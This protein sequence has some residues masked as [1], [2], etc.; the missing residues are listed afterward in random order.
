[1]R[2]RLELLWLSNSFCFCLLREQSTIFVWLL[3]QR[4]WLGQTDQVHN[5]EKLKKLFEQGNRWRERLPPRYS[6]R[7][8]IIIIIITESN[9]LFND[10]HNISYCFSVKDLSLIQETILEC[11]CFKLC[12]CTWRIWFFYLMHKMFTL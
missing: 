1:M 7:L 11:S 2:I 8:I 3:T 5:S 10:C 12:A 4:L 6:G 9:Q